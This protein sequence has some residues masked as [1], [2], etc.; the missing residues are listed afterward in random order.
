M[1]KSF[2]REQNSVNGA[3]K[4]K[5]RCTGNLITTDDAETFQVSCVRDG[6]DPAKM[7]LQLRTMIC[8]AYP[9]I[10]IKYSAPEVPCIHCILG[11][12]CGNLLCSK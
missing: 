3:T 12:G 7:G 4:H 10:F 2:A 9:P 1:E 11:T 5:T 6:H 8:F